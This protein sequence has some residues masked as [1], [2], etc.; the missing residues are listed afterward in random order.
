MAQLEFVSD[1][2]PQRDVRDAEVIADATVNADGDADHGRITGSEL[3]DLCVVVDLVGVGVEPD[4]LI[5]AA[6]AERPTCRL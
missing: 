5:L 3:D 2:D 6:L 4:P 1:L